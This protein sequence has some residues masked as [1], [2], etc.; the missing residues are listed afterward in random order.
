MFA[1]QGVAKATRKPFAPAIAVAIAHPLRF[2]FL[3]N[4]K[5][6]VDQRKIDVIVERQ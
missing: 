2:S 3:S 1:S 6:H 4:F 5:Q